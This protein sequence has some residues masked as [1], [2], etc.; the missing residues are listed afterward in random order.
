[1]PVTFNCNQVGQKALW[2]KSA[3][4]GREVAVANAYKQLDNGLFLR[5]QTFPTQ[6]QAK[7]FCRRWGMSQVGIMQVHSRFQLGWAIHL[8]HGLFVPDHAE[9]LLFSHRMG[10]IVTSIDDERMWPMTA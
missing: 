3:F 5:L 8:G 10:C 1:M 7:S 2:N 4:E 9:G 6:A